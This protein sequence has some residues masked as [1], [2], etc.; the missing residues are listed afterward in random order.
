MA[1]S[2]QAEINKRREELSAIKRF[3]Y[4]SGRIENL[5]HFIIMNF[6][7]FTFTSDFN[8]NLLT[9]NPLTGK[10]YLGGG[11]PAT[12]SIKLPVPIKVIEK[13]DIGYEPNSLSDGLVS[14]FENAMKNKASSEHN[15]MEDYERRVRGDRNLK[16]G[17]SSADMILNLL[18]YAPNPYN[19]IKFKGVP[20][21]KHSFRWKFSPESPENTNEIERI[22]KII[23]TKMHPSA[24]GGSFT[25]ILNYP[26][27]I[28][29]R[30]FGAKNPE[31]TFPVA[32]CMIE[33][34]NVDRTGGDYPSYFETTGTP[35]VYGIFMI[36]VE[37]LPLLRFGDELGM[38][39]PIALI[40]QPPVAN[41]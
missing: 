26:E 31:H 23:R 24:I 20:L 29:F 13:Y 5:S 25:P 15:R 32:P 36:V 39:N 6:H 21:R 28:N 7:N 16:I 11:G 18:G 34:F 14:V 12:A 3:S 40:Q 38:L 27:L 19:I 10:G 17:K 35:V 33:S 8:G 37:I 1:S 4:P 22:I 30:V 2:A 9:N 41:T